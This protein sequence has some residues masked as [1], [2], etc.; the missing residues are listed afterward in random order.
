M[1]VSPLLNHGGQP[2]GKEGMPMVTYENL[3]AYT[4]V[5]I[6]LV[7]ICYQIFKGKK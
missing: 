7:E 4:I 2:S 3:F 5:L 1:A 6:T